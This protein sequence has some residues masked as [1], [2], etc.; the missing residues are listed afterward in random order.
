MT[1]LRKGSTGEDVRKLQQL[2]NQSGY[3][4]TV[5]GIFGDGTENAVKKFQQE[6]GLA[7][8]GIVGPATWDAL[9]EVS[10]GNDLIS[11]RKLTETAIE[12]VA[13]QLQIEV[14][15]MKAVCEVESNG[16]GFLPDGRPKIL[17]EG[18]IFWR[19]L[20]KAGMN[21]EDYVVG[22]ENVLYPSWVRDYYGEDQYM[23]LN[24]AMNIQE[25]AALASASWGM[26]QIMGFN[27]K[28]CHFDTVTYYVMTQYISEDEHLKA[29]AGFIETNNLV[30]HLQ[31][32]DWA[33]FA[34][35]YNGPGY[36][37]NQ[38]DVKLAAAYEKYSA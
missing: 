34:Y 36:A 29:F 3:N 5:D 22:N 12:E 19:E 4:L 10:S 2:L 33:A 23:R 20:E 18:H 27:Y 31:N 14:A 25:T 16:E 7:I 21:P 9:T 1:T 11:C 37:E 38:Y 30:R 13:L 17:F 26:F 32:K 28:A 6:N 15:A 24:K 35:G 8:D